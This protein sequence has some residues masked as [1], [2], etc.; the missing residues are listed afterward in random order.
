MRNKWRPRIV[1]P[2]REEWESVT[3]NG[4][5]GLYPRISPELKDY[6]TTAEITAA[7]KDIAPVRV[8]LYRSG[9]K[10]ERRLI[11]LVSQALRAKAV[12]FEGDWSDL[13]MK[14][15]ERI[16]YLLPPSVLTLLSR[17]E[18]AEHIV[19]KICDRLVDDDAWEAECRNRKRALGPEDAEHVQSKWVG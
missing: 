14:E 18:A 4:G 19:G 11:M 17:F 9:R 7:L 5:Y 12:P 6:A 2:S 13:S 15:L 1:W 3:L 8:S 16:E 10:Q